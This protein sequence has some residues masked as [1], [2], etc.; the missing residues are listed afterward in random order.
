MILDSVRKQIEVKVNEE[1]AGYPI[2]W[3]NT[4]FSPPSDRAWIQ[5][6][7]GFGQSF[8]V[9]LH[10]RR[11]TIGTAVINIYVP[12]DRGIAL[13]LQL[14][15]IARSL[16]NSFAEVC[17]DQDPSVF[18]QPAIGPSQIL[19]PATSQF[20]GVTVSSSFEVNYY[21]ESAA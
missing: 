12:K 4:A 6:G 1:F 18:F 14:A 2:A 20:Y 7:M 11:K 3:P 15:E 19:E 8:R 13:A 21:Q 5:F 9:G 10:A 17:L 16:F